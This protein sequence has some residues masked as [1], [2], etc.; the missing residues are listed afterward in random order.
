MT[1]KQRIL[2]MVERW[3]DDISFDQAV[4]HMSVLQAVDEGLK[5]ID[6]GRVWD[7]DEVFDELEQRCDEEEG[8][9][10]LVGSSKKRFGS[11]SKKNR[12]PRST[13]NGQVVRKPS[14]KA[15]K[16]IT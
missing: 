7:F 12:G 4:Y 11:A 10:S 5:D 14:K 3:P 9:A 1:N 13:K 6:A 16:P 2:Q 15:R 8:K